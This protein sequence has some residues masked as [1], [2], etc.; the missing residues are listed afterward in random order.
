MITRITDKLIARSGKTVSQRKKQAG[1]H[2]YLVNL[3]KIAINTKLILFK[4]N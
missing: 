3:K 1:T 4:P 2:F